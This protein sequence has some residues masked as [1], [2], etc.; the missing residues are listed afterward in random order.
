MDR[1]SL[2]ESLHQLTQMLRVLRF[3]KF[4]KFG[5]P[6]ARVAHHCTINFRLSA[7][8]KDLQSLYVA[9]LFSMA[10]TSLFLFWPRTSYKL[11]C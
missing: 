9:M 4:A 7:S 5:S 3:A 1:W 2:N 11:F 8:A 6:A 10:H